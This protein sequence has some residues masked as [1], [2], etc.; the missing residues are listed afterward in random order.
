MKKKSLKF[1]FG[2][3]LALFIILQFMPNQLP[4]NAASTPT[5]IIASG[6]VDAAVGDI[7]RTACYDCHSNQSRYPWYA[8][9]APV[10]WLVAHDVAEGREELN[11]STWTTYETRRKQRKTEEIAEEVEEGHMPLPIYTT[12]HADAR[13][14]PE[15]QQQ[16]L[17]WARKLAN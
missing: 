5:D 16:L 12:L 14:T 3:L 13:L 6:T 7:L 4:E 8:H 11:F 1:I 9:V 2:G 15:Q 10:S 17:A